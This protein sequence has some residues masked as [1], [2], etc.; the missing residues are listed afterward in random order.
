[1]QKNILILFFTLLNSISSH[2]WVDPTITWKT[3]ETPHFN[4]IYDAKQYDAAN[5]YA[6]R[7][8]KAYSVLAP[9]FRET[10]E[11]AVIVL[12]D[13]TDMPNGYAVRFPYPKIVL[14]PVLP[15]PIETIGEYGDWAY[16]LLLHEY[17][18][19]LNFEPA[20]GVFAPLRTI[21]GSI[22]SPNILLPRWWSEGIAVEFETRFS[23][24]GRLR[25]YY[26]DAMIRALAKENELPLYG[27]SEANETGIPGWPLGARPYLFGS[28]FWSDLLADSSVEM[29]FNLNEHHSRRMPYFLDD[30]FIEHRKDTYENYY[31]KVIKKTEARAKDQ[32]AKLSSS[33]PS[34]TKKFDIKEPRSEAPTLSSDGRYLAMLTTTNLGQRRVRIFDRKD[35]NRPFDA[36]TDSIK[37]IEGDMDKLVE[38][39][40]QDGPPTG[41][42]T[43]ISWHP[44]E[45]RFIYDQIKTDN[46]YHSFS[47]LLSYDLI[48]KKTQ[49]LSTGLRAREPDYSLNGKLIAFIKLENSQTHLATIPSSGGKEEFLFSPGPLHRLSYPTFISDSQILFAWRDPQGQQSPAIYNLIDKKVEKLNWP[50]KEANF[51]QRSH[52]QILFSAS[53]TGVLNL[54]SASLSLDSYRRIT[55]LDTASFH[56]T[57]DPRTKEYF[58]SVMTSY[59]VQVHRLA[60]SDQTPVAPKI[61]KLNDS[62]YPQGQVESSITT[63]QIESTD[64]SPWP[65]L[66][67]NYWLP[68]FYFSG[69]GY[70]GQISTGSS[71][72]VGHH[73]YSLLMNYDSANS[74]TGGTF[75]YTNTQTSWI[76]STGLSAFQAKDPVSMNNYDKSALDLLATKPFYGKLDNWS[77]GLGATHA[78]LTTS[79]T[80]FKTGPKLLLSYANISSSPYHFTPTS[81]QSGSLGISKYFEGENNIN[82]E[83]TEAGY[84]IYWSNGLVENHTLYAHL[85]G[86]YT[87]Q[88]GIPVQEALSSFGFSYSKEALNHFLLIRGYNTSDFIT[89]TVSSLNLEYRLP[90]RDVYQGWG[91]KPIYFKKVHSAITLDTL[92]GQGL[93]LNYETKGYETIRMNEYFY[94]LGG[95]V[96]TDMTVGYHFPMTLVYGIYLTP[97]IENQRVS[98]FVGLQM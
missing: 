17:V 65:Y 64:Y 74:Q 40:K 35:A 11:K 27:I 2:A 73:S 87:P 16:E 92:T 89:K 93:R 1:M 81:G 97:Q 9:V 90:L 51:F 14:Y 55:H 8:E 36:A 80:K 4:I 69:G 98:T 44:S 62:R 59:G 66:I 71:D 19:L 67:P 61:E 15:G 82:Y 47:D 79:T 53:E 77:L 50:L 95:E 34:M 37:E 30:A 88:S 91:L 84:T 49:R 41:S 54:F 28:L 25:S 26:Q 60:G 23:N 76:L 20:H 52:D 68:F 85:Y 33:P 86:A 3:I 43:R 21:F 5:A 31:D 48:T 75:T 72:P 45:P 7:A 39:A 70:G 12:D 10:P 57:F 13:S 94:S 38:P 24:H 78:T 58:T 6:Q 42:I 22:V 32:L 46:P 96:R 63:N 56:S 18:H 29:A 83:R